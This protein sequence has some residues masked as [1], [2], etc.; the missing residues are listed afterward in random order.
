MISPKLKEYAEKNWFSYE[1]K[2]VNDASKEELWTA[3]MLPVIR[4]DSE[5]LEFDEVLAKI[6]S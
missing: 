4:F 1:E 6:T 2:D 5:Q 3:T